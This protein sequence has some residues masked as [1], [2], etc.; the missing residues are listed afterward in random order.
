[1]L[2]GISLTLLLS[3]GGGPSESDAVVEESST[4][5]YRIYL[6]NEASGDLSIIDS[7]TM[8]V[9]STVPLRNRP[10]G[11]HASPDGERIYVALSGSPPA[12]PGVET[13][14]RGTA[15]LSH[16]ESRSPV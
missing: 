14:P 11:V 2:L 12:P 10:R 13:R 15:R 5:S 7:A 3:C 9:V 8:E 4:P 1:M 16:G 6:T